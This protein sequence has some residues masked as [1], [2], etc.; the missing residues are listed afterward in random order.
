MAHGKV[1]LPQDLLP[2]PIFSATKDGAL[3]GNAEG[4]ALTGSLDDSKDHL[5][6]ESSI[7][8]SP[9]WLHAKS[10]EAKPLASGTSGEIHAPGSLS[11]GNSIDSN[12]RDIWR[13]DGSR[14]RKDWRRNAPDLDVNRRWR[15]EE[16]E[17]GLLGRRD[18][19]KEDRRVGVTST[20]DIAEN[21]AED[22]RAGGPSTRDVSEN[23]ILS[24]D[25]WHES[26]RDNKWSSRWGP[27]DKDKDSRIEKTELEREDAHVDKQ[28]LVSSNR[29]IPERDGDSRD[30]WRPRH[31]MEVQSGGPAPYRAA[32]GFGMARG[33]VEKVGFAS[34]RGRSKTNG[35][36][37]IGKPSSVSTIG[38]VLDQNQ[39]VLGNTGPFNE[40]YRYPRGKLL[41]I[42]RKQKIESTFD[43][44]PDGMEH[45]SPI[46]QVGSIEPLAFSAPH[47]EE[48]AVMEDIWKGRITSSEMLCS[49]SREKNVLNDDGTSNASLRK[50]DQKISLQTE[51]NALSTGEP[52][53]NNSFPV[54]GT[55][56]ST[57][58]GPRTHIL[59]EWVEGERRVP[60]VTAVADGSNLV[61]SKNYDCKSA[62]E[63]DG[64]S[65]SVAELRISG[66]QDVRDFGLP[67]H[68]MSENFE[69]ATTVIGSQ[70]PDDSSSLFHIPS[71]QQTS[72]SDQYVKSN[73]KADLERV[74][75][76]E[77]L[78]LCYLDPQG[79]IQ[80]PFLGIDI[81]SWFDQGFFGTD[82]LVRLA[83]APNGSPFQELG[84]MMPNLNT[85]SGLVSNS[86]L[87]TN[88]ES[89]G[90]V[91]S[92]LEE[93]KT[94]P[95]YE[96]SNILNIQHWTSSGLEPTLSD[97]LHSR[98]PNNGYNSELQYLDNQRFQN[99]VEEDE[100]I[101]FPGRPKSSSDFPLRRPS[102]DIQ[103]SFSNSPS[104]P[105]LSNEVSESDL[106]NRQDDKLHPF[107]LLMSELRGSSHLRPAQASNVSLGMDD[108]AQFRDTLFEGGISK[109]SWL[110]NPNIPMHQVV[111]DMEH[112]I[113]LQR[114]EQQHRLLELQ[115]QRQFEFHRQQQHEL[116]FQQ[117]QQRQ[118]ELQQQRQL[119]LQQQRQLEL[120]HLELQQQ[121]QLELQLQRQLELQQQRQFELQQQRQLE[122]QQQRQLELQQQQQHHLELQQQQQRKLELQQ[123]QRH[124]Q[125][126]QLEF[127]QQRQLELQQQQHQLELP[128]QHHLQQHLRHQQKLQQQQQ[129]QAE[130][131]LLEQ[132]LNRQMSDGYGQWKMDATRA[133]LHDQLHSSNHLPNDLHHVSHSSRHDP[134]LEQII[135]ATMGE[136]ALQGQTDFFDLISQA[137]QGNRN[138]SELPLRLNEQELQ[139]QQLSLAFREQQQIE[140]ER[141]IGGPWFADEA[142]PFLRDPV[143]HHQ[144]HMLGHNSSEN[145]QQQQRF[146]SNEQ[147]PSH[148]DWSHASKERPQGGFYES[149]SMEFDRFSVPAGSHGMNL[150]IANIRGQDLEVREQ[151]RLN[152]SIDERG[153]LSSGVTSH[154]RLVSD[155]FYASHPVTFE[156]LPSGNNGQLESSCTEAVMPYLHLDAEQKR[157]DTE[158]TIAFTASNRLASTNGDKEHSKQ[159]LMDLH[160]KLG[161]QPTQSSEVDYQHHLSSCRSQGGSVHLPLNLLPDQSV[162][163][164]NCFTEGP[165]SSNFS[166]LL[167][168]QLGSYGMNEQ[169]SN[170]ARRSDSRAF[171]DAQFLSGTRDAPHE[172]NMANQQDTAI[173]SGELPSNTHSRHS[174]LSSAGGCG[175]FHSS[176]MG[177]DKSLGEDVSDG[178]LPSTI[179]KGFDS[180]TQRRRVLSSQDVSSESALSLP[181][182]PR[183]SISLRT[184]EKN[185]AATLISESRA[186]RKNDAQF[187]RTSSYSDAGVSETSFI[188]VLKKPVIPEADVASRGAVESS[189]G[190]GQVG[191]TGKKKGKKG[192]QI[193]PALLGF[194][195]SSNRIMMGEIHRLDE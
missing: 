190:G 23:K 115:Q 74:V 164:S 68:S 7:P 145:Y 67:K 71:L 55:E 66:C 122:L 179:T 171:M 2:S 108:Q 149:N 49:S 37:Q 21:R 97:D 158:D 45:V 35:S 153:S 144:A 59:N 38:S 126:R 176:E 54:I 117:Q 99:Y 51:E 127:Q 87:P 92:I 187:R 4:K 77:D 148:N 130:Q 81:I 79:N 134:S 101:V 85:K 129:S 90:G 94:A 184:S 177:L 1:S 170:L 39:S 82:L 48:E 150:D 111:P 41:D 137:K 16:R 60:I 161:H 178:R 42:Y 109:L 174:S 131:L 154:R 70:L 112:L 46:T 86:N 103:G 53:L 14:D 65:N 172:G 124:Q 27:E 162:G 100:E 57:I 136:G 28:S 95:H 29:A 10:V 31:R 181:V 43:I 13:S 139:A 189:D 167:Q 125:Q 123:L 183:S 93:R 146:P 156:S 121:H 116:E 166:L 52:I 163:M 25:R 110:N 80:G 15:E 12:A 96:E 30:K 58:C 36:L 118:L 143:G 135:Q 8:L 78:S 32:P 106:P 61:A 191:R 188:D 24:S 84:E 147:E 72:S 63:I 142:G 133:N 88:M 34:G 140:G 192:R 62:G 26:R 128:P 104:L 50:E 69:P 89:F 19:K 40:K 9:Q 11:H 75:S 152:S 47:A 105:S 3:E 5:A 56:V 175:G 102:A 98:I 20:R 193:D 91:G 22:H 114:Q 157:R 173:E 185:P 155:E 160:Q 165:Q 33:Q 17:T 76:F 186:S 44:V 132:L 119:E 141:R 182:K 6:S 113:E 73:E 138:T 159:I 195:V 151:Y 64:L 194:K 83:D 18:R 168:D 180:A 107:G 169:P 120:H